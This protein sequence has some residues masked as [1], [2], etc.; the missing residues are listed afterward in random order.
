MKTKPLN[1]HQE[2]FEDLI[3]TGDTSV[4][5][6]FNGDYEVSLK[7]DGSPSIIFGTE[8]S[9]G[10]FVVGTKSIFNK[11]KLKIN[12]SHEEIDANHS[13]KVAD[14]LHACLD[15][16]PR[17]K[18]IIQ[19]DFLGFGNT[20]TLQPNTISYKFPEVI[21]QKIVIAPHTVWSTD[22]ELKD[23]YVSGTAPFFN[24]TEHV[25][26]VQPCVDLVR[27]SMPQLNTDDVKFLTA[28]E[29]EVAQKSINALIREGVE[30]NWFN[31]IDILG[32]TKL[33]H[34]YLTMIE[35]KEDLMQS[36]IVTDSP[37]AFIG[38]EEIV[39]EGF[40]LKNDKMIMK[41]VDRPTFAFNNFNLAKSW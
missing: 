41:L 19:C 24:D 31:L 33:A 26:F 2:H 34:L 4:L 18:S 6:F 32:D 5:D 9:T 3:L 25:K 7:I 28:K 39:G 37:R 1:K 12:H 23:A 38:D 16:L 35:I 40:V 17:T 8:P 11:V 22:G 13:G 36:M 29:A 27:P 21:S 30:L 20:D 15:Y 14:I 10:K